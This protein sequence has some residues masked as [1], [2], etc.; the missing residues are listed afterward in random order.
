MEI[1]FNGCYLIHAIDQ[2]LGTNNR[3]LA[4]RYCSVEIRFDIHGRNNSKLGS[5][6]SAL[7]D[8]PSFLHLRIGS[9]FQ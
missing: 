4:A 6:Q 3:S 1:E 8:R 2:P 5:F 7:K 9:Y